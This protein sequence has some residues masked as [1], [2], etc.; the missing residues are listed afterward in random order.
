MNSHGLPRFWQLYRQLP[1]PIR[2]AARQTYHQFQ[3]DSAHSSLHFHRLEGD[4]QVWSVR[5][6]QDYRAVGIR[7][8]DTITWIWIGSHADF[9]HFSP[10]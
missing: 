10:R 7:Q 8:G 6:T 4:Q 1:E 2:R 5:I 3:A 9:D